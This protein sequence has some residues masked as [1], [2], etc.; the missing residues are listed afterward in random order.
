MICNI[1][2]RAFS[3][4][5]STY[6]SY[7]RKW[8]LVTQLLDIFKE[9][10]RTWSLYPLSRFTV[11]HFRMIVRQ[12]ARSRCALIE[13]NG[14][15]LYEKRYEA[16]QLLPEGENSVLGISA[17][18][19]LKRAEAVRKRI[20]IYGRKWWFDAQLCEIFKEHFKVWAPFTVPKWEE[21]GTEITRTMLL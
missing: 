11:H 13:D 20:N 6:Q 15:E 18:F 9:H 10:F 3:R 2:T 1:D 21:I 17:T 7:G 12:Q 14:A 4:S 16:L 8:W 5:T 19:T